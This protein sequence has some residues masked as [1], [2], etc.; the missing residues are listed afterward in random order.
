M[1]TAANE[2]LSCASCGATIY[3]EHMQQHKADRVAGRLLCP[4]CLT[5]EK[6]G[7]AAAM[8]AA[9]MAGAGATGIGAAAGIG[10]ASARVAGSTPAPS[11]AGGA[12]SPSGAGT[13]SSGP[14]EIGTDT[15][16]LSDEPEPAI[17]LTGAADAPPAGGIRQFAAAS[18]ISFDHQHKHAGFRR[19]LLQGS[20]NATRCRSF[21]A[22]LTDAALA[23]MNDQINEWVD[24]H[25]D[26]EIKFAS[27][28]IGVV[29]G[30]HADPHV[31]VTVFY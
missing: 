30:K 18:G 27:S 28:N 6:S 3:P 31:I 16:V 22:K 15:I 9:P 12:A 4:H 17:P 19:G 7:A 24:E 13:A 26:I 11:G 23:H 5:E 29:E 8:G 2:F 25:D 21:H 1:A 10:V 20:G 14:M